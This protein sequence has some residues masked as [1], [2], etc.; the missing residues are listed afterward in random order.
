[1][2]TSATPEPVIRQI[3]EAM[4]TLAGPHPGFRPLLAK[5]LV[6]AGTFRASAEAPR[7]TRASH[8][9]GGPV[10]TIVR[11]ANSNGNPDVHDGVPNVRSMAVKFQLA[12]KSADILA[13]SIQGFIA[14][15]PEE[16][17]EILRAQ[18]PQPASGR[19][20]PDAVPRFLAA[21]PAGRGFVERL[22]K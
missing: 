3:V 9:T 12:D 22:M 18:L 14:R 15:T 2:S 8:F 20:D 13:N 16:L 1:M 19:P 5:G 10:S 7:V 4:R 17:L 6:C 21:H 11:F